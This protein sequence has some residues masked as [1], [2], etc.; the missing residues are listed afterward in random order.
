MHINSN[1]IAVEIINEM[2]GHSDLHTFSKYYDL[3][4]FNNI[5]TPQDVSHL[6]IIHMNSRSLPKNSDNIQSFLNCLD[7][8]LDII[9]FSETW[10]TD[11]TSIILLRKQG[12]KV[13]Q[14]L[15]ASC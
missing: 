13:S 14:S 1:D 10:L 9:V 4:S 6:N 15:F 7:N 11:T 3:S 2:Y 8:P 5:I 12:L